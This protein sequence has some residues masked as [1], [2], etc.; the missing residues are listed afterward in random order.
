MIENK[1]IDE[2]VKIDPS[3]IIYP[4]V[5][6]K[7]N[8]TIGKN[9]VI[10]PGSYIENSIIGNNVTIYSS[11]VIDSE[12]ENDVKIGPYASL[13]GHS[14]I[15]CQTKV[16]SFCEV[17]NTVLNKNS[18]IPHLSY[19]G[20]TTVGENVNIGAGTITANY[21]GINKNKTIIEDN[22]FIGSNTTL[23]APIKIGEG[24]LIAAGSTLTDDV[25]SDSLAIARNRQTTK[26]GYYK[27]HNI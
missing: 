13:R 25:P 18:K 23:I 24:S 20:D 5:I 22:C 6:I 9:C 7:G 2:T 4:N 3:A 11:Y 21:D 12:I 16:G 10:T 1:L 8:S 19:V 15:K 27:K 26:P 14:V 17:K